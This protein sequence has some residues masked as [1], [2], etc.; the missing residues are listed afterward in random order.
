MCPCVIF[1]IFGV[2]MVEYLC[3]NIYNLHSKLLR[4]TPC[5]IYTLLQENVY[6]GKFLMMII[7]PYYADNDSSLLILV[8][9][10]LGWNCLAKKSHSENP[11][12]LLREHLNTL[13]IHHILV[14]HIELW[15]LIK[16]LENNKIRISID[17]MCIWSNLCHIRLMLFFSFI[18]KCIN[19]M[20]QTGTN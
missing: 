20:I 6:V 9:S 7:N 17:S 10:L 8:N 11:D 1:Y 12:Q 18:I 5:L 4:C 16:E 19:Y 14:N 13:R 15:L 3:T 2:F